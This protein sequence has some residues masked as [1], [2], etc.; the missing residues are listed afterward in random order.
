MRCGCLRGPDP[1][2]P[3]R[4]QS[5]P[6][7]KRS[8]HAAFG[9]RVALSGDGNTALI[10]GPF[11]TAGSV[12]A[13]WVFTRSGSTW[14]QDASKL[15]G[16]GAIEEPGFGNSVALSSTGNTALIGGPYDNGHVGAAWVFVEPP[17]VE[18]GSASEVTTVSATANATVN[19]EGLEVSKCEFEYGTT[20]A[21]GQIESCSALPGSGE[22]AVSVSAPL[23][24]LV[25]DTTYHFRISATNAASTSHGVDHTFTTLETFKTGSN[26]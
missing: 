20:E 12:G 25:P 7:A 17:M 11:D 8:G 18:T 19:P 13:S 24:K 26:Q 15:T 22:S 4:D 6:E 3:N 10:G 1:L 2:G 9:W 21:Y 5:S 14:T 16:S 23:I